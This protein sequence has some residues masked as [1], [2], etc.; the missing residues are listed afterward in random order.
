MKRTPWRLRKEGGYAVYNDAEKQKKKKK[1][2]G[3]KVGRALNI[4]FCIDLFTH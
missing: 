2:N 4:E 1:T 3:R